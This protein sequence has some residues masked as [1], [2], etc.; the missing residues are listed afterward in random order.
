MSFISPQKSST[1]TATLIAVA[2]LVHILFIWLLI[3]GLAQK[4][5][6]YMM[7]PMNASMIEE[8]KHI[9]KP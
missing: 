7:Q 3:S 6:A 9:P 8:I 5:T 1:G 2:I 4:A